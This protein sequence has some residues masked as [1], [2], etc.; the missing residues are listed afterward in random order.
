MIAIYELDE[1]SSQHFALSYRFIGSLPWNRVERS[2]SPAIIEISPLFAQIYNQAKAA[3]SLRLSDVAGP[4]FRKAL[5]FLLKDYA[6]RLHPNDAAWIRSAQLAQVISRHF[7]DP[8]MTTVFSRAAW[9]GNDQTHYERRWIDRDI[10]DL[11]RLIDLA[12]HLIEIERLVTELPTAM[13]NPNKP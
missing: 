4:G 7:T 2:F 5:E 3:D 6:I 1:E 9:L 13:P 11:K 12:I 8:S 10:E